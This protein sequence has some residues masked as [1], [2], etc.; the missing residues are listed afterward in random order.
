MFDSQLNDA[1]PAEIECV[2]KQQADGTPIITQDFAPIIAKLYHVGEIHTFRVRRDKFEHDRLDVMTDEGFLFHITGPHADSV[3]EYQTVR[4]KI[5]S[6]EGVKVEVEIVKGQEQDSM[7]GSLVLITPK[8]LADMATRDLIPPHVIRF[9]LRQFNNDEV[10]APARLMLADGDAE[11]VV[12]FLDTVRTTMGVWLSKNLKR[13]SPK[14]LLNAIRRICI[15]IIERSSIVTGGEGAQDR[16]RHGIERVIREA[17]TYLVALQKSDDASVDAFALDIIQSL[18]NTGYIYASENRLHTLLCV[19]TLRPN[20]MQTVVPELLSALTA[21]KQNCWVKDP[22]RSALVDL[23]SGYAEQMAPEADT[24]LDLDLGENKQLINNTV[25]A[26]AILLLLSNDS[27]DINRHICLSRLCR[28]ASLYNSNLGNS[29]N[30]RAY[31]FLFGPLKDK[32]PYTWSDIAGSNMSIISIK[33]SNITTSKGSKDTLYHEGRKAVI[34]INEG[35]ISILPISGGRNLRN[36]M[37]TWLLPWGSRNVKVLTRAHDVEKIN[38][39]SND[40]S[41]FRRLWRTVTDSIFFSNTKAAVNPVPMQPQTV[42]IPAD[43]EDEVLIRVVSKENRTDNNGCPIFR[44]VI[45]DDRIEGEGFISPLD[46][47]RYRVTDA[48]LSDFM[49]TNG[50]PYLFRVVVKAIDGH[51]MCHF[52]ALD[53]IAEFLYENVG[54]GDELVCKMTINNDKGDSLLISEQGYSLKVPVSDGMPPLRKGEFVTVEITDV[55]P[56]GRIFASYLSDYTSDD[57]NFMKD[58]DCLAALV[59]WYSGG[60]VI[61]IEDNDAGEDFDGDLQGQSQIER[62]E[63]EELIKIVERQ[64]ALSSDRVEAYNFLSF[65]KLLAE[66]IQD[67]PLANQYGERAY[68]IH[69]TQQ[70]AIN[71]SIDTEGFDKHYEASEQMLASNADLKD[72]AAQLYCISRK[73]KEGSEDR[74]LR[75]AEEQKGRLTGD[76]ASLVLA[77]NIA[78]QHGVQDAAAALTDKINEKLKIAKDVT[79]LVYLG[80]ESQTLEFK[81]SMVFPSHNSM[82]PDRQKQTMHILQRICGMMNG[83]GGKLYVGVNDQGYACGLDADFRNFAD[84][85]ARYDVQKCEDSMVNYFTNMLLE[86]LKP[87][88]SA[89]KVEPRFVEMGEK[90]VLEISIPHITDTLVSVDGEYWRRYIT[91]TKKMDNSEIKPLK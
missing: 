5:V 29:L 77:H 89:S 39:K 13:D 87:R 75:I 20:K 17:D 53:S 41:E 73:G 85:N 1:V 19:L 56:S 83:Q 72:R 64:S 35:N 3:R 4:G 55:Q 88:S 74:L 22:L 40:T 57:D 34:V 45:E 90:I 15:N 61:E 25:K 67:E 36:I 9:A 28:Y 71:G 26:I 68:L 65:A 21:D 62:D 50:N 84:G 60:K 70:F 91:V 86:H 2:I 10:F 8:V 59:R 47:V 63:M 11:W 48:Q 6:I 38:Q 7:E 80:A 16:M 51:D 44:C 46:I 33:M 81:T 78:V 31:G 79:K 37:P 76:I 49:D 82:R 18:K 14:E 32:M 58:S 66:A 24:V 27:D 54:E 52:S 42:K 69:M 30:D 43:V 12:S 23:L